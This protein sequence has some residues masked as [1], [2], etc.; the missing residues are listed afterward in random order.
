MGALVCADRFCLG[1]F[2][3]TYQGTLFVAGQQTCFYLA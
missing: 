3:N 1:W 2:V